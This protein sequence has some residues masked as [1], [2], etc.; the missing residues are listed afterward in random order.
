MIINK[1]K[2]NANAIYNNEIENENVNNNLAL[3]KQENF[4]NTECDFWKNDN[5]QVFMTRD[6]IGQA[7]E[8]NNPMIAIYKIHERHKERL[9]QFSVLTKLTNTDGKS[10]DTYLYSAKGV[11]EICRWSQQPKADTFM[12]WVWDVIDGLRT[13]SLGDGYLKTINNTNVQLQAVAKMIQELY[14]QNFNMQNDINVLK[15]SLLPKPEYSAWKNSINPKITQLAEK[16]QIDKNK[17]LSSIYIEIKKRHLV[18]LE[19]L[20]RILSEETGSD[21]TTLDTV[22][23][24]AKD[25]FEEILD[26]MLINNGLKELPE[27]LK[28]LE[29]SEPVKNTIT[30]DALDLIINPLVAR[31]KDK[32]PHGIVTRRRIFSKMN[33][34]WHNRIT[35]YMKK[36]NTEKEPKKSALVLQ[37]KTL[38]SEFKK[39]V[40]ILSN[41]SVPV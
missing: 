17:I 19:A 10:Y 6:Q 30:F 20:Q 4:G 9:D 23:Q 26:E 7:L 5:G 31:Y 25:Y 3:A 27:P 29:P 33:V 38:L 13:G 39:A 15:K 34:N 28:Q 8:Y 35:R 24:Y 36:F 40:K 37:D 11:Y 22:E 14:K 12:N 16:L 32:S 21:K 41:E 1:M 2:D 18:N